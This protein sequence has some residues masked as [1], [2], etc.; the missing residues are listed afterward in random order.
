MNG[1]GGRLCKKKEGIR[2][3]RKKQMGK[4]GENKKGKIAEANMCLFSVK[5]SL[6]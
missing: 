5:K 2:K 6:K 3:K 4:L 1:K